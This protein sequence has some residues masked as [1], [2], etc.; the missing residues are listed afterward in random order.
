MP[1]RT[2]GILLL[3][4]LTFSL[5]AQPAHSAI[6][7]PLSAFS[8]EWNK[9]VFLDL[10]TA[11][12]SNYLTAMEKDLIWILNLLRRD[13]QLFLRT[14]VLNPKSD[15]YQYPQHRNSY[16]ISLI[17]ALQKQKPNRKPLM[18][19]QILFQSAYCHALNSGKTGFVGHDRKWN[20]NTSFR[21]ECISYGFDDALDIVM[22]LLL[23]DGVP[24]LGHRSI[25]LSNSYNELGISIQ[26]HTTYSYNAV[27]D[28]R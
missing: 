12:D 17:K 19:D 10:N 1:T 24:S 13:P 20:C 14:V 22:Q 15:F 3:L 9:E 2:F 23:D 11:R 7:S 4:L 6:E 26:P 25:C 16:Y 18:P 5:R 27:L 21:G 8:G 28:F